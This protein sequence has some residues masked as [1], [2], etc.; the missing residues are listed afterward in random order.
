ML[1][2]IR[3][4]EQARGNEYIDWDISLTWRGGRSDNDTMTVT[5]KG[6]AVNDID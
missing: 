1:N 6:K 5:Q 4:E 2:L 3:D